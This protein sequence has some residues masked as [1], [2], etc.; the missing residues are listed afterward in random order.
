M[1]L[2]SAFPSIAYPKPAYGEGSV[3]NPVNTNNSIQ[4]T[5]IGV[6]RKYIDNGGYNDYQAGTLSGFSNFNA[7][8]QTIMIQGIRGA[9]S[10]NDGYILDDSST[11]TNLYFTSSG[12]LAY[13]FGAGSGATTKTVA[14]GAPYTIFMQGM[15]VSAVSILVDLNGD[16]VSSADAVGWALGTMPDKLA[17]RAGF[18][19][20]SGYIIAITRWKRFLRADERQLL[21]DNP[22]RIYRKDNRILPVMDVVRGP[23]LTRQS[24][25]LGTSSGSASAVSTLSGLRKSLTTQQPQGPADIDRSNPITIGFTLVSSGGMSNNLI[26]LREQTYTSGSG[27]AS[28]VVT[29]QGTGW[30]AAGTGGVSLN[31]GSDKIFGNGDVTAMFV[32]NPSASAAVIKTVAR[33]ASGGGLVWFAANDDE[34]EVVSSGT[35]CLGLLETGVNRSSVKALGAIDGTMSTYLLGKKTGSGIAY[36]N[37]V[38]LTA[39]TTGTLGGSPST[40]AASYKLLGNNSAGGGEFTDSLVLVCAWDRLLSDAEAASITSNPWQIFKAPPKPLWVPV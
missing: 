3:N 40:G 5:R 9:Y 27:T 2:S 22:W 32:G 4:S 17:Q 14:V 38:K 26:T 19:S 20:M 1:G 11:S 23:A 6:G 16:V 10:A 31:N 39:T 13:S 12:Q 8:G 34:N 29:K 36:K 28:K 7:T 30:K 18:S 24:R 25:L 37:G 21:R 15:G 35:L 33:Q